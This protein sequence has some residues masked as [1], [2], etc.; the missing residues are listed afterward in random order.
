[1]P[2]STVERADILPVLGRLC[3]YRPDELEAPLRARLQTPVPVTRLGKTVRRLRRP[4]R[5]FC[6]GLFL[7]L[8]V[9]V[10]TDVGPEMVSLM[11]RPPALNGTT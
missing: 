1:M 2:P 5:L 10:T 9:A 8:G 3:E 6:V 4:Q 11:A 7:R